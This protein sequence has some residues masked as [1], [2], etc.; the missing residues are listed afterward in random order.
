MRTHRTLVL[1]L[2]GVPIARVSPERAVV[3]IMQNKAYMIQTQGNEV[4]HS[5]HTTFP[6]PAVIGLTSWYKL[7]DHYY[8]HARL[9]V[10]TLQRRDNW[11]CQ[12]CGREK[13][14]LKENEFLT[15]DHV[16]P[17]SRGGEDIWENVVLSCNACNNKKSDRTPEEAGMKLLR[18]PFAP[19]R[20]QLNRRYM[21]EIMLSEAT[22][23]ELI[24]NADVEITAGAI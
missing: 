6:V 9:S 24:E 8:G 1:T 14:E 15:R 22:L 11:T 13:R 17:V 12:Y 4:F 16:F 5:Q 19:S 21:K 7:P 10:A 23:E 3:L 20:W 18:Q 2:D